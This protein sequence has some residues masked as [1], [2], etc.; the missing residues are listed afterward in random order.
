MFNIVFK[1]ARI[2]LQGKSNV[3]LSRLRSACADR[4]NQ[5]FEFHSEGT[6][7]KELPLLMLNGG[8]KYV[9]FKNRNR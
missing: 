9:E 4:A 8:M 7:E 3:F 6:G 1:F 5:A 2:R